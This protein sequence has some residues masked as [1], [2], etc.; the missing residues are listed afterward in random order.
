MNTKTKS[1]MFF[2]LGLVAFTIA[3]IDMTA[4]ANHSMKVIS[5]VMVTIEKSK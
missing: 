3:A 1:A 5:P 4:Q 2:F